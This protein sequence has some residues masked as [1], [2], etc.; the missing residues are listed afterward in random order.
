M[1]FA[2]ISKPSLH[3]NTNTFTGNNSTQTFTGFNFKPDMTWLKKRNGTANHHIVDAVRG[4]GYYLYPNLN[5]AQGGN[6]SSLLTAF[7][8]DGYTVD[9]GADSNGSGAT[10]VGW[11]WKAG[12]L[13]NTVGT[14]NSDGSITSSVSANTTAGFSIVKYTGTGSNATVGHGL[15]AVPTTIIQKNL[16]ATEAWAVY[17]AKAAAAPATVH[18]YLNLNVAA[19]DSATQYNDTAPTSS[20]FSVGTSA[21][22]NQSGQNFIAYCFTDKVGYSKMGSYIGN[23]NANGTF[24]YTGFKPA[25]V[26]A[27]QSSGTGD[28]YIFDNKRQGFNPNNSEL[29]PSGNDGETTT[30]RIDL[31][32]NGFKFRSS[33]VAVNDNG[34][35][36]IFMA[37]AEE[38]LVANVGSSIPATAR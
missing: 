7:T 11:S 38:P 36:H 8:S 5:N 21:E 17:H 28:W 14:S 16:G 4:V 34:E 35:T 25:L 22:T 2:S 26:I 18:L 27:K 12:N 37:F 15:G 3:F 31:L 13:A 20:V 33:S 1:A 30:D 29:Y 6:G 32:S 23:G 24:V 9:A 10:G 19:E